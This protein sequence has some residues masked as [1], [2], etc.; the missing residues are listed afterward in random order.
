[1]E[2][3][4]YFGSVAVF[5]VLWIW[6]GTQYTWAGLLGIPVAAMLLI[7]FYARKVRLAKNLAE[8]VEVERAADW[9]TLRKWAKDQGWR[10]HEIAE[11]PW[12]EGLLHRADPGP[13]L[14][15]T[16]QVAGRRVDVMRMPFT[17]HGG[18]RPRPGVHHVV[19]MAARGRPDDQFRGRGFRAFVSDGVLVA[20][21]ENCDFEL[22]PEDALIAATQVVETLHKKEENLSPYDKA[23]RAQ[24]DSLD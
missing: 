17:D 13:Y 21:M 24:E 12:T 9:I 8:H 14:T 15:V 10:V 16:G 19:A 6:L 11:V 18:T 22:K 5:V 4:L 2:R 23:L 20:T 1:M 3:R 7:G